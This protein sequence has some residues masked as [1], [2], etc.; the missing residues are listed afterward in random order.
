MVISG[1]P[2]D[3]LI[4]SKKIPSGRTAMYSPEGIFPLGIT[5]S[6]RPAAKLNKKVFRPERT[7]CVQSRKV[8]FTPEQPLHP[9]LT[10]NYSVPFT[11]NA[12]N[13]AAEPL[14]T[15]FSGEPDPYYSCK[16][17][18]FAQ[19]GESNRISAHL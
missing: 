4:P 7:V 9:G 6:S 17:F 14:R 13:T 10:Q 11:Q 19:P 5:H 18:R 15:K 12:L 16:T 1:G 2:G 8:F 3:W